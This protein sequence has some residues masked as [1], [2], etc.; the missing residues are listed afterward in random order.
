[1]VFIARR[2]RRMRDEKLEPDG[3]VAERDYGTLDT[4]G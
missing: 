4:C 3:C 2:V 1:V